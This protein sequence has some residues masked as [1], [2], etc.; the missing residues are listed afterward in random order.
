MSASTGGWLRANRKNCPVMA[1]CATANC[2]ILIIGAETGSRCPRHAALYARRK[3]KAAC[4][5][6]SKRRSR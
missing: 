5:E 1:L 4:A 6:I 2:P 3:R